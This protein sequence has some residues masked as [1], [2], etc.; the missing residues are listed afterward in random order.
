MEQLLV[1][2]HFSRNNLNPQRPVSEEQLLVS[3][4]FPRSNLNPQRPVSEEQLLVSTH[5]P[6]SNLIYRDLS[7]RNSFSSAPTFQGVTSIHRVLSLRNSFSSAPTFQGV[8]SSTETCL[9]VAAFRQHPLSKPRSNLNPQI[10]IYEE[11][12]FV[13]THFSRSNLIYRD[14]SLR[15][16]FSSAPTFQGV[17]PSTETCLRVAA[18][19]QHPLFKESSTETYL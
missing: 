8:T 9:R 1:S 12:L 10:L 17:T 6:R 15:N 11:Q 14:P 7:L 16:S 4:H 5:F 3:T 18:S 2:T 19:R 13:S